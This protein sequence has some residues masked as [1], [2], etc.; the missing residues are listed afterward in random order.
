MVELGIGKEAHKVCRVSRLNVVP[1]KVQ[2]NVAECDGVSV[3]VERADGRANV[4]ALG[5][6]L[7]DLALEVLGKV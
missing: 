1:L 2:R 5:F 4:L 7:V 6:G 3:D